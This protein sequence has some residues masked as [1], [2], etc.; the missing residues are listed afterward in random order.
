M[1]DVN[2]TV[3]CVLLNINEDT[4]VLPNRSIAEIIPIRNM[5]NVANK[6]G[7][8][9]GYLDWRGQSVPL[10]SLE[11]MG[12]VRMPSLASGNVKAAIIYT[13]SDDRAFPFVAVL[14]QGAPEVF[15]LA[16]TDISE[17]TEAKIVNPV[18][19]QKVLVK[20]QPASIVDLSKLEK[21]IKHIMT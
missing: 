21:A 4:L 20:E 17:D 16:P 8:M 3:K 11:M 19:E 13:I 1:P 2:A 7:W 9:L 5:I 12:G 14:I 18:I 10:V 6:P 15:D